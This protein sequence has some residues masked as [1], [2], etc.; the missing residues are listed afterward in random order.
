[1]SALEHFNKI[2]KGFNDNY[3][4]AGV[5][6]RTSSPVS[7]DRDENYMCNIRNFYPCGEGLGHGGG[8]ISAAADGIKVALYI[9]KNLEK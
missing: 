4:I 9:V 8:I 7:L 3:I 6:T 2:I 5:E 1:M